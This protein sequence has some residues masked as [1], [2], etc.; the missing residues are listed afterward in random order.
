MVRACPSGSVCLNWFPTPSH[1]NE[2][3]WPSGLATVATF[4]LS[5]PQQKQLEALVPAQT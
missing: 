2:V 3:A 4:A 1:S 5:T